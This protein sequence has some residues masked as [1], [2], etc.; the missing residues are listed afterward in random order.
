LPGEAKLLEEANIMVVGS[1]H[2]Q[3]IIAAVAATVIALASGTNVWLTD[4]LTLSS[5]FN[6]DGY[7]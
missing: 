6:A 1:L 3:R 5:A 2:T 4:G 7:I